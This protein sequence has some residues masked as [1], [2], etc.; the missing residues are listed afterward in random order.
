MGGEKQKKHLIIANV[1]QLASDLGYP[2]SRDEY[3]KH[4]GKLVGHREYNRLFGSYSNLLAAA[5]LLKERITRRQT[6]KPLENK[7]HDA[8]VE[9]ENLYLRD[10]A[11]YSDKFKGQPNAG[12]F[13]MV[14]ASDF[15]VPYHD[16]FCLSVFLDVC[17]RIQPHVIALAGDIADFYA[18]SRF[19]KDPKRVCSLKDE[20]TRLKDELFLPLRS[21]CPNAQI[22][23]ILGNHEM[24][25][26]KYLS[27]Q[28][29][30]LAYL[31]EITIPILFDLD[32]YKINLVAQKTM[33]NPSPK[34][35]DQNY[36]I[37]QDCFLVTHGK[38]LNPCHAINEINKWSMSGV[39][40]HTHHHQQQDRVS[41]AG[42]MTWTS[43]G[44]MCGP[45]E[46]QDDLDRWSRGFMV[47]HVRNR[48]VFP[49]YVKVA[50][51]FAAYGGKYYI[52]SSD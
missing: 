34:C 8:K 31:D 12:I 37:Y 10:I 18:L 19:S 47:A 3:E 9:L 43:L 46:Y 45:A 23:F 11:P 7:R 27:A 25:L 24:R 16:K 48:T 5:G 15:H 42:Q 33:I 4:P 38:Y 51:G 21:V 39:S 36:K 20:I 13:R 49:E 1:K 22:D 29:P 6:R 28:A 30:G 2:P 17:E 41:L 44:C 52:E 50:G 40:G 26:I 14:V 35:D 32:K